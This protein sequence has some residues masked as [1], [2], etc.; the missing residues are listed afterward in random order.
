MFDFWKNRK[1]ANEQKKFY[2]ELKS[3]LVEL[4]KLN[5]DDLEKNIE[6]HAVMNDDN[7]RTHSNFTV[8]YLYGNKYYIDVVYYDSDKHCLRKFIETILKDSQNY[9][10]RLENDIR[11]TIGEL[12]NKNNYGSSL[13]FTYSAYK[14]FVYKHLKYYE[15]Y[16]NV[17][18]DKRVTGCKKIEYNFIF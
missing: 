2:E 5:K 16:N 14:D 8:Q 15:D 17:P 4:E 9:Q 18:I 13:K 12:L 7:D 3:Q 11:Y 10:Q 1:K 6:F